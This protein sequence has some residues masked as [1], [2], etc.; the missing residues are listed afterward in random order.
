[1]SASSRSRSPQPPIPRG[2]SP[3]PSSSSLPRPSFSSNRSSR[4]TPADFEAA[5][6][7][8]HST[9]FLSGSPNLGEEDPDDSLTSRVDHD[10]PHPIEKKSYE[11]ELNGL[12]SGGVHTPVKGGSGV[13]LGVIP[14]TPSTK[15]PVPSLLRRE[16]Q[17]TT[18]STESEG[19]ITRK[20]SNGTRTMGPSL[21]LDGMSCRY[22]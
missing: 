11:E 12:I 5:L 16:S 6:L 9:V 20:I 8:P 19:S 1:M 3:N 21:G 7:D 13:G 18:M 15:S 14:P 10:A 22:N 2:P 4:C 17:A